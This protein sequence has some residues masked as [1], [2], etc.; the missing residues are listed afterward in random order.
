MAVAEAYPQLKADGGFM[1]LQGELSDT[2]NRIASRRN[3]FNGAV[4][5]YNETLSVFPNNLIAGIFGFRSLPFLKEDDETVRV[6]PK[7]AF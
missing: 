4:G 7:V 6:A 3:G 2:E 1:R 5:G